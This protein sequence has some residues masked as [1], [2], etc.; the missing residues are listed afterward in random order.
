MKTWPRVVSVLVS[1]ALPVVVLAVALRVVTAPWLVRWE[2]G[3]PDFPP[4]PYGLTTKERIR[5]AEV[6]VEYLATGAGIEL[7]ADLELEGRPAFN[8]RELAHMVDVQRVFWAILRAGMAAGGVVLVGM[9]GLL[10]RRTTRPLAASALQGGA[11][12]TLVLL[13]VVA[14]LMLTSWEVFFTGFHELFFPPDTWTFP[15]SDTLIRLYPERFWMDVGITIVGVVL[16]QAG[17]VLVVASVLRRLK[18]GQ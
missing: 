12:L 10:A 5:L 17:L 18:P 1:L 6:C 11:V 13:V 8:E 16:I 9:A 3:K 2:Y 14:A 7:L 4:D 15:T